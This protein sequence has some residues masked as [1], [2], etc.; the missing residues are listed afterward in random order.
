MKNAVRNTLGV[1]LSVALL[2]WAL[3][4]VEFG[5]VVEHLRRSNPWLFALA[6][7]LGASI[8]PV[9]ARRGRTILDPIALRLPFGPLWRATAIGFAINNVTPRVGELARPYSLSRETPRVSFSAALASLAVDRVFD[10]LAI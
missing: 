1:I 10:A 5:L 4:N 6:V 8:F 7:V 9:R 2:A 3:H